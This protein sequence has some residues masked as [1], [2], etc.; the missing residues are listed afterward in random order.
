LNPR[1]V[2]KDPHQVLAG[3]L[4]WHRE[5]GVRDFAFY[6]DALL[7]GFEKHLGP[8]LEEI[9]RRNLG[10]RFHTPNAVHV[11]ELS[12]EAADLLWRAG[13]KTIRLGFETSD[14]TLHQVLDRKF[15]EGDF[16]R[17][18]RC[19]LKAGFAKEQIGAY[20]LAGLPGQSVRSVRDTA[21]FVSKAGAMPYLA[22]YS[23]IPHTPLW[24]K[25]VASSRYDLVSEPLF[26]NNTL[27]P[28]WNDTQRKDF[29]R[30]K[31]RVLEIRRSD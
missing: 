26:H 24:E 9:V 20:I 7:V 2:T 31:A 23:P 13:F 30:V 10:L 8:M 17:A 28:C 3:I 5:C 11:K 14:M 6:D 15:S 29:S 22:E 19:L 4:H 27:L 21:E 18:V 16:E 1:F 25:A 12:P